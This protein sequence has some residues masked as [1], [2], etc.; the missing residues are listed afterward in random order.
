MA[1]TR[2]IAAA[3][4]A[5]PGLP[6]ELEHLLQGSAELWDALAKNPTLSESTWLR[7]YQKQNGKPIPA[8]RADLLAG[9]ALSEAQRV[10][11]IGT[12]R[13]ISALQSMLWRNQLTESEHELLAAKKLPAGVWLTVYQ[14]QTEIRTPARAQL[15]AE[16]AGGLTL[17]HH[18]TRVSPEMLSDEAVGALLGRFKE[19][20]P[21]RSFRERVDALSLLLAHRPQLW[22][23]YVAEGAHE[24]L[25]SAAAGSRQCTEVAIQRRIA[26]LTGSG[27]GA[28]FREGVDLSQHR[29]VVRNLVNNPR[30]G[31]E[32]I[33][34]VGAA[35]EHAVT[36]RRASRIYGADDSISMV[37][38]AVRFRTEKRPYAIAPEASTVESEDAIRSLGYGITH[39]YAPAGEEDL[40]GLLA[41]PRTPAWLRSKLL[42]HAWRH[43]FSVPP[44]SPH[45][46]TITQWAAS[47]DASETE[48]LR[49]QLAIEAGTT[50]FV[51]QPEPASGRTPWLYEARDVP[52]VGVWADE[53]AA[54]TKLH[55]LTWG[56]GAASAAQWL[57]RR[58]TLPEGGLDTARWSVALTLVDEFDGSVSELAELAENLTT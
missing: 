57:T 45:V 11:L 12:E 47:L 44:W 50:P 9:R 2:H 25:H 27:S 19:W 52:H 6:E 41:N 14:S 4:A 17:L 56:S 10:H 13:R 5:A 42:E 43:G 3:I 48:E 35:C 40:P 26:G 1:T 18:L 30:V 34:E 29:W 39:G 31:I 53:E 37:E 24:A 49:A 16:R 38:N 33:A 54:R 23:H 20:A 58:W 36:A 32:V 15:W 46:S 22:E 8:A 51:V 21:A 28:Q 55:S 7:L